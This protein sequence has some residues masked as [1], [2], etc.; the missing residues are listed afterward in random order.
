V[1]I[2][3]IVSTL[4]QVLLAAA[5]IAVL[6]YDAYRFHSHQLGLNSRQNPILPTV[7]MLLAGSLCLFVWR[8]FYLLG[9]AIPSANDRVLIGDDKP[10]SNTSFYALSRPFFIGV[11]AFI[12]CSIVTISV[13]WV[14]V[15]AASRN[16]V[17]LVSNARRYRHSVYAFEGVY[18][19]AMI[20]TVGILGRLE[21]SA[22]VSAPFIVVLLVLLIKGRHRMLALLNDALRSSAMTSDTSGRGD[23]ASDSMPAKQTDGDYRLRRTMQSIELTARWL[24]RFLVLLIIGSAIYF[25]VVDA[26]EASWHE[27]TRPG[28][29]PGA[30]LAAAIIPWSIAILYYICVRYMHGNAKRFLHTYG[31]TGPRKAWPSSTANAPS[32]NTIRPSTNND[33]DLE[34]EEVSDVLAA[35]PSSS[36]Q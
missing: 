18:L 30:P 33:P 9:L 3:Q 25:L 14:E 32:V 22:I 23:G 12:L 5:L 28:G 10:A 13:I 6:A 2:V 26:P 15:A 29:F 16:R 17:R 34:L 4:L 20:L 21:L 1:T 11:E 8:L 24:I 36:R 31:K 7:L 27:Y 35:A 19:M